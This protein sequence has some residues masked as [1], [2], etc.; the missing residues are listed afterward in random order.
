MYVV[1][2][3]DLPHAP[4]GRINRL[5]PAAE[6]DL[7]QSV[8]NSAL[9]HREDL[10]DDPFALDPEGFRARHLNDI[11]EQRW[12]V[13]RERGRIVFEVHIGAE[14]NRTVQLGGV[15][16]PPDLRNRGYAT[17]GMHGIVRQLLERRPAVSLFCDEDNRAACHVYE[18]LGF[19]N[20]FYYRSWLLDQTDVSG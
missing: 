12:W 16:T 18:K 11:R 1:T 13:L 19:R 4:S 9:Q 7:D 14:N 6:A 8:E 3:R 10:K 2:A 17:R 5:Q 20:L 15:M